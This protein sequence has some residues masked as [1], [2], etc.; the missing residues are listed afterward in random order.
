MADNLATAEP[1]MESMTF[2]VPQMDC[3]AE[4]QLVR[5]HLA[6]REDV[7]R[8]AFDLLNRTVVVTHSGD[9]AAIERA[10]RDLQLGAALVGREAVDE[11]EPDTSD[12][13]QR[14][15]L[16]IVLLINAG[17]FVL[18]LVTGLIAQSMG[19]VADSLDMLADAIVY[20]LSLYAVGKALTRKK[21]IA[22]MSGYFQFALAVFGVIEVARRFLGAGDEPS[23]SLMIGISL[24]AFAGN[25]ASLLVLQ[26]TRSQEVH[27]RA[28]W[29]FT[30]NDVLVN[31]GVMAAGVLVLVTGSKIPDLLVGAAVFCL[32]GYGAFRIL[33]LSR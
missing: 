27:I 11:L 2:K 14:S 20:S 15:L 21:Q 5:M 17:L 26:R 24:V 19:L 30:T 1:P 28:S 9:G 13:R 6:E 31:L 29:I 22:R 16:I 10:M 18:E 12:E 4:E 8:L 7:Q 33:K 23:F 25:V 3:A 32:V